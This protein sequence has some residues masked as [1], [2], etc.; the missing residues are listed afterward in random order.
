MA[1]IACSGA[2]ALVAARARASRRSGGRATRLAPVAV[3]TH[4]HT[5]EETESV[6]ASLKKQRLITG[7]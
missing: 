1:S 5:P 4:P 3:L 2:P 7:A 6:T